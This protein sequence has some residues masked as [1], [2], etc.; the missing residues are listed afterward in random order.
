MRKSLLYGA[1]GE[2]YTAWLIIA[3]L[4]LP[5]VRGPLS[6]QMGGSDKFAGLNFR[7]HLEGEL[8]NEVIPPDPV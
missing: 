2:L 3:L 1:A 4:R 7:E 8:L 5:E 6:L